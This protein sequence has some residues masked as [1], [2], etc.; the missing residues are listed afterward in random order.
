MLETLPEIVFASADGT[1]SKKISRWVKSGMLRKMRPRVY[2]SNFEDSDE[3]IVRRNLYPILGG[4]YPDAVLS[5]RTALEAG[6]TE[7][8]EIF[9][10]YPYKRTVELPGIMDCSS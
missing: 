2:T 5:H 7:S 9:L 10:T 4:L 1:E 6:P 3:T 8:S